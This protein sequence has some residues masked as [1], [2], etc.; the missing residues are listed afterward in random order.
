MALPESGVIVDC[1]GPLRNTFFV[2]FF[3]CPLESGQA[4]CSYASS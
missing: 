1:A 3:L 2:L 4:I